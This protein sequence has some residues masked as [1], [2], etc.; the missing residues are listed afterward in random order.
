MGI[1]I[2]YGAKLEDLEKTMRA[3]V[4]PQKPRSS[5]VSTVVPPIIGT[6]PPSPSLASVIPSHEVKEEELSTGKRSVVYHDELGPFLEKVLKLHE[7]RVLQI[8]G[9]NF[10]RKGTAVVSKPA[11]SVESPSHEASEPEH[12]EAVPQ[13]SKVRKPKKKKPRTQKKPKAVVSVPKKKVG[14]PEVYSSTG[15]GGLAEDHQ[16][17]PES[18]KLRPVRKPTKNIKAGPGMF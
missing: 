9:Q 2:L 14:K 12:K 17:K 4:I 18:L 15:G 11:E 6:P 13:V 10:S 1:A 8:V 7:K 16:K 3:R 5:K